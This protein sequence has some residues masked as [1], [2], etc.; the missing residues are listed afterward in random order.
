[1]K[2]KLSIVFMLAI[3]LSTTSC[4]TILQEL[5]IQSLFLQ[6]LKEQK[7]FKGIEN[8]QHLVQPKFQEVWVAD[9]YI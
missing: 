2:N 6:A 8:V 1:M 3:A 9:S 4:A 7:Y 5:R